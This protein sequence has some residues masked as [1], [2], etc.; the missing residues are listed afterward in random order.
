M[1]LFFSFFLSLFTVFSLSNFLVFSEEI[2]LDAG[3]QIFSQNCTACHAGG[4]NS[5]NP[6]KTLQLEDLSKYSKDTIE[7]IVN[8]INNGAGPMPAFAGRLSDDEIS[9]VANYVL[10]QAK[11]NSW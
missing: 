11:N 2:D 4:K 8:Q 7:A 6:A 9:N 10:N 1:R 3:E 5:V